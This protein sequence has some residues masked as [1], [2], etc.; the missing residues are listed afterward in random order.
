M[1][2]KN[3]CKIKQDG[4]LADRHEQKVKENESDEVK[5]HKIRELCSKRGGP[6]RNMKESRKFLISNESGKT[7]K[8]KISILKNE[9]KFRKKTDEQSNLEYTVN[10]K[11]YSQLKETL[12]LILEHEETQ[13]FIPITHY[14]CQNLLKRN[15][16]PEQ[17]L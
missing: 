7:E 3:E 2:K 11:S 5:W 14:K 4:L 13:K 8:E 16:T 10:K 6:V 17:H 12:L 1:L 15:S 9:I